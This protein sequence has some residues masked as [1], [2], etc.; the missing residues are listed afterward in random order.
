MNTSEHGLEHAFLDLPT[1]KHVGM[2]LL[3]FVNRIRGTTDVQK[4]AEGI[5]R[6]GFVAF[7]FPEG[8]ER[9]RMH[10]DVD[11]K[12]LEEQ[13][14]LHLKW[15]PLQ[16]EQGFHVCEITHAGQ[17]A[18]AASYIEN[19]NGKFLSTRQTTSF[20]PMTN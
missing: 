18:C 5:F 7:S 16:P 11:F 10:V 13:E 2:A 14:N 1:L 19:A 6:L 9:I 20:D 3:Q 17:L 15:L 12:Q 4:D 8:D